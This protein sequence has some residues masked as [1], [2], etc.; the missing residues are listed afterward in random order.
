M[1]IKGSLLA[2]ALDA[3]FKASGMIYAVQ[4]A[5]GVTELYDW[6]TINFSSATSGTDEGMV[7]TN[8]SVSWTMSNGDVVNRLILNSFDNLSSPTVVKFHID[9]TVTTETFTSDGIYILES[10]TV[11]LG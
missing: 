8:A 5:N 3:E 7:T 11:V 4:I 1:K 9:D 2:T 6:K 10:V